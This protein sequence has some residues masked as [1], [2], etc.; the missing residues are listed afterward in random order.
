MLFKVEMTVR[1]PATMPVAEAEALKTTEREVAQGLMR[2]GRWRHLWRVAGIAEAAN[3]A[4]YGGTMLEG[5]VGTM[6]SAQLFST[7]G[8]LAWSTELFGPLLLTEE[9]L[10]EPL[11]YRDFA[12]QLP[13]TPGLGITLDT[14]RLARMRRA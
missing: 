7:F 3:I 13:T 11:Q 10:Q 9:I 2:Q 8:E 1:L 14:A 4:L 12:L 5:A 6:A